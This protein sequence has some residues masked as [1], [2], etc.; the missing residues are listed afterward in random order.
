[1]KKKLTQEYIAQSL[2]ILMRKKNLN[3]IT[4]GE[5]TSK[6]GVNRSTYYR[7]FTSKED[8]LKFFLDN[9]MN[10]Y[11]QEYKKLKIDSM[12]T[13]LHTIFKHF[14][15]YKDELLL[16]YNSGFAYLLLNSLNTSFN[17]VYNLKI[18]DLN[19]QY[20]IYYHIGGIYNNFIL[21]FSHNMKESPKELTEIISSTIPI[22]LKPYL[23]KT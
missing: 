8:I 7:N 10:N 21:W 20:N 6:A 19:T 23:L 5:I 14:Y 1:M 2:L 9:I 13:Y 17:N 12:K 22:D 16:I 3:D 18:A 4:I 11:L 15:L